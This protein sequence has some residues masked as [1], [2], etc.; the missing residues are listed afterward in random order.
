MKK[1]IIS[2][3]LFLFIAVLSVDAMG[4]GAK[5]AERPGRR[6]I[7]RPV[8]AV[9]APLDTAVLAL[10]GVAGV[11]YYAIRKKKKNQ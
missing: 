5:K 4:P 1:I 9:A 6:S 2:L 7:E 11:A 10:L 8:R 3:S